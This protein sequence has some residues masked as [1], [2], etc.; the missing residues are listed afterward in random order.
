MKAAFFEPAPRP[1]SSPVAPLT[2]ACRD[3]FAER[4]IMERGAET[5]GSVC[6]D[7]GGLD[8]LGP[9]LG[10]VGDQL[11]KVD[12]G[13]KYRYATEVGEMGLHLR[14]VESHID[15]IVELVDDLGG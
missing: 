13:R 7:T 5:V 12:G 1:L 4:E 6:L 11:S 10:F 14:V 2:R 8:H 9:F 3:A 15:L